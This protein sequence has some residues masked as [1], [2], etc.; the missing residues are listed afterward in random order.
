MQLWQS[1][2]NSATDQNVM[3]RQKNVWQDVN[4]F[5]HKHW[6]QLP[7]VVS[8]TPRGAG[9]LARRSADLLS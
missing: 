7:S 2:Y 6:S 9:A 3:S 1:T 5:H 8:P 4:Y